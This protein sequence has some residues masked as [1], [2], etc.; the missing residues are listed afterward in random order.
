MGGRSIFFKFF[1]LLIERL[2]NLGYYTLYQIG[3]PIG[4]EWNWYKAVDLG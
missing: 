2:R 4:Y 1:E 3:F